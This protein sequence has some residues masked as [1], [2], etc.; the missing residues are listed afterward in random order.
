MSLYGACRH[1]C[2]W[3]E[4]ELLIE[5]GLPEVKLIRQSGKRDKKQEQDINGRRHQ[6]LPF[7]GIRYIYIDAE[8][9]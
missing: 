8:D 6:I 4:K 5:L 2:I 7:S 3:W 9:G 1:S